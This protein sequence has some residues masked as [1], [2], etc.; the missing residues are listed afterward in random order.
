VTVKDTATGSERTVPFS[1]L[2]D[3]TLMTE[4]RLFEIRPAR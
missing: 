2:T 4:Y 3:G 1:A